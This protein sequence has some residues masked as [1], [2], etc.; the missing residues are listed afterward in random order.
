MKTFFQLAEERHHTAL[1]EGN[2]RES[3]SLQNKCLALEK[4]IKE[5]DSKINKLTTDLESKNNTV[6]QL[7]VRL[8]VLDEQITLLKQDFEQREN[9][10]NIQEQK[11]KE[12]NLVID[13]YKKIILSGGESRQVEV[14]KTTVIARE[15]T[16]ADL[17]SKLGC[18]KG[19]I[20]NLEAR[21]E[22]IAQENL[23]H[24]DELNSM[25]TQRRPPSAD[26]RHTSWSPNKNYMDSSEKESEEMRNMKETL[27]KKEDQYKIACNMI[28]SFIITRK[29]LEKEN[30]ELQ[31]TLEKREGK[32]AELQKELKKCST[33]GQHSSGTSQ[34]E[35][36]VC[37]RKVK[38]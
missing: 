29:S 20:V 2:I 4:A 31:S 17:E 27:K 33:V 36:E 37:R 26:S 21:L 7:N 18:C 24:Q 11:L 10:V 30:Y 8:R 32:I 6:S 34:Q 25:K 28:Q 22:K 9:K 16:I 38:K 5:R 14:L 35:Y 15:N 13:D 12:Q 3:D 19:V 23:R 1:L